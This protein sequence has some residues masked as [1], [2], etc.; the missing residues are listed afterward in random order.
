MPRAEADMATAGAAL[1][2]HGHI[3]RRSE[4]GDAVFSVQAADHRG[5]GIHA[6][7]DAIA[8]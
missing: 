8:L 2:T 6:K 7:A 3:A 1:Q 4:G 5:I